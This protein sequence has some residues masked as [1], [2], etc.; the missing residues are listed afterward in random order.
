MSFQK[1]GG[2][3]EIVSSPRSLDINMKLK[4]WEPRRIMPRAGDVPEPWVTLTMAS[5][6]M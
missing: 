4:D 3:R 1:G 2:L 6:E 5:S